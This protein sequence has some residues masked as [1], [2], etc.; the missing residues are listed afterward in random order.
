MM[1]S[2]HNRIQTT[3]ESRNPWNYH[4]SIADYTYKYD[5]NGLIEKVVVNATGRG[6][7]FHVSTTN[8]FYE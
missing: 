1:L 4:K 6:G 5:S 3:W 8:F 7:T 2:K